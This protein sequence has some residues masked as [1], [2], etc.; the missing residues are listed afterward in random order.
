MITPEEAVACRVTAF[1]MNVGVGEDDECWEWHGYQEDGY[2]RFYFQERMVGAHELA[3]TFTTG[4]RRQSHFDTC[5]SCN[6][7]LCCNPRHLRFDT[8]QSNVDDAVAAGRVRNGNTRLTE[9]EVVKIRERYASGAPQTV[10]ARDF[11]ISASMVSQIVHGFRWR[12]AGGPI[13]KERM[14]NHDR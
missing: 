5:H 3:L 8:R 6:N 12:S 4:E 10:L 14:Y 9:D 1:W 7:P 11:S 13:I 2:G